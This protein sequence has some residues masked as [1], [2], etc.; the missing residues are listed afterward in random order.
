LTAAATTAILRVAGEAGGVA[1][2]IAVVGI[3]A[4]EVALE[5]G[6]VRPAPAAL[7][8][9]VGDEVAGVDSL[10]AFG[11]QEGGAE[12]RQGRRGTQRLVDHPGRVSRDRQDV[13]VRREDGA[14]A[15]RDDAAGLDLADG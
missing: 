15:I 11:A 1:P 12:P 14:D 9:G 7:E 4:E 13:G 10:F 6:D 2:R 3:E 8:H 5:A